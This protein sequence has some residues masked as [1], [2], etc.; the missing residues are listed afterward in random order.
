MENRPGGRVAT[1]AQSMPGVSFGRRSF[2]MPARYSESFSAGTLHPQPFSFE[3]LVR[4]KVL[5][6]PR[7]VGSND[8]PKADIFRDHHAQLVCLVTGESL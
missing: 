2:E 5:G 3:K 8:E 1:S 4:R 6:S 7:D